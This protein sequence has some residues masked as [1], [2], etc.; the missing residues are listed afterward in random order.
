MERLF[1]PKVSWITGVWPRGAQ[2]RT[3]VGRVLSPL[4]SMKTMVRPSS[5]AFFYRWPLNPLPAA[6]LGFV[7]L[8]S[9]AF[10]ALAAESI[11]A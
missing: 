1:Q 11:V 9:A 10:W 4:S 6:D 8:N 7:T 5:P 2:V 3:R